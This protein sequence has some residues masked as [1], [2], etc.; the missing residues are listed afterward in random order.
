MILPFGIHSAGYSSIVITS[1]HRFLER[2]PWY[3]LT[4]LELAFSQASTE[5]FCTVDVILDMRLI[6]IFFMFGRTFS[7]FD[8]FSLPFLQLF[9]VSIRKCRH[10][11]DAA[12]PRVTHS[13][14][15]RCLV[16]EKV[17]LIRTH[18]LLNAAGRPRVKHLRLHNCRLHEV[19]VLRARSF[20]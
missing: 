8:E 12:F 3:V 20:P 15:E 2:F 11:W 16:E 4:I 9:P 6:F 18:W 7:P 17:L 1:L 14:L 5:A 10:R 13:V 19:T